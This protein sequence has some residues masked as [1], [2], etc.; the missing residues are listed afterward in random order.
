MYR[1]LIKL[2]LGLIAVMVVSSCGT[3]DETRDSTLEED[4]LIQSFSDESPEMQH[5]IAEIVENA[6]ARQ[7]KGAMN[8]L[9]LL[10]ATKQLSKKQK[11]AVD[12]MVRQY[13]YDMEEEIFNKQGQQE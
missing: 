2:F 7:F 5:H 11:Y 13:R 9:A 10:S 8:K 4:R 3:S 12:V 6:K 1:K